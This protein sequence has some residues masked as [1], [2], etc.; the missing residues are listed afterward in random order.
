MAKRLAMAAAAL[1]MLIGLAGP[2]AAWGNEDREN[3]NSGNGNGSETEPEN[4]CDPGNSGG[5]NNGGD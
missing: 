2:A 3:C 1:A 5:H 4:D